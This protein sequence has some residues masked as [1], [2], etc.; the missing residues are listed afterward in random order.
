MCVRP[1]VLPAGFLALL[2]GA[3]LLQAGAISLPNASFES[4]ATPFVNINLN[5]WQKT[6][7]PDWYV[8]EGSFQWTQLSGTFLNTSAGSADHVDNCDGN[9]ALWLFAIPEV[10]LFQD[11]DSVD[12]AHSVPTHAFAERFEAGKA[13]TLA[14]GFIGGGGNMLPGASIELALYFRDAASNQVVVAATN[15]VF[16]P[17]LFPT[18]T[19]FVDCQAELP[20]VKASDAWANQHLGVRLRSSI[21]DT[22]FVG[23]Y[24]DV[25]NFRLRSV[26][27]PTIQTPVM[28]GSE[29]RFQVR[30]EPGWRC[31]IL[32]ASNPAVPLGAWTSLGIVTNLSGEAAFTNT[33][34]GFDRRFYQVR[35]SP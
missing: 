34:A 23:G 12:W 24:W 7:K 31:E 3:R 21:V 5:S 33:T 25:D 8:E 14:A 22:N 9:Q 6:P 28:A 11:Y 1:A 4:P 35:Q 32:A 17:A 30:G 20:T 10:G 19:H 2:T 18:T 15:I 27:A 26:L 16:S 13:Y 29:F